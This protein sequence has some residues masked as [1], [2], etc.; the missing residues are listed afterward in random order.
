MLNQMPHQVTNYWTVA[1]WA[2]LAGINRTNAYYWLNKLEVPIK[3]IAGHK[4]IEEGQVQPALI[5]FKTAYEEA[6]KKR[7]R[8]T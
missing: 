2:K 8:K 7:R 6:M 1:Q 5:A 3:D 4:M